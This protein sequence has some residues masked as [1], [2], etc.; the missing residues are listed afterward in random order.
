MIRLRELEFS[1]WLREMQALE[2]A[3]TMRENP[4]VE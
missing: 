3:T 4:G 2:I 1:S